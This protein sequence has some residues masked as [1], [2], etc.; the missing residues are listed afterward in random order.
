MVYHDGN[1]FEGKEFDDIPTIEH[2][3]QMEK[4]KYSQSMSIEDNYIIYEDV[5]QEN[6][7]SFNTYNEAWTYQKL[8]NYSINYQIN[9]ILNYYHHD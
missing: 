3:L 1:G 7:E 6:S 4:K 5:N 8:I 2:N 9:W